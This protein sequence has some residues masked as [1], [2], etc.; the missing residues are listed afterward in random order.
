MHGN[1]G[2]SS[3]AS[4]A[5]GKLGGRRK[6]AKVGRPSKAPAKVSRMNS[7]L[8]VLEYLASVYQ[9]VTKDDETRIRAAGMFAPYRY[10]RLQAV[11]TTTGTGGQNHADWVKGITKAIKESNEPELKLI[12][13]EA[14]EVEQAPMIPLKRKD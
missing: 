7:R 11:H 8:D 2:R 6:G 3:P 9:D 14:T 5:N 13:G 12:N 10:P 1:R 4:A